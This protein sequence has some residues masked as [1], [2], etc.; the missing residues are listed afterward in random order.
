MLLLHFQLMFSNYSIPSHNDT[1]YFSMRQVSKNR[2]NKLIVAKSLNRLWFCRFLLLLPP[3]DRSGYQITWNLFLWILFGFP[4]IGIGYP[5]RLQQL[6]ASRFHE[7]ML[8]P[9]RSTTILL[10]SGQY[11]CS[12]GCP[13]TFPIYAYFRP[14][15]LAILWCFSSVSI[16]VFSNSIIL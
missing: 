9:Y 15:S 3:A 4:I 7:P 12:K 11:V 6:F 8:N 2:Y 10:H 14:I 5:H 16:G 13:G 1:S